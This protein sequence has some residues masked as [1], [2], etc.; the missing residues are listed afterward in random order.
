MDDD[1][2][3]DIFVFEGATTVMGTWT[4]PEAIELLEEALNHAGH[5]KPL[6]ERIRVKDEGTRSL[7]GLPIS[8]KVTDDTCDNHAR[9][10]W[11]L[12]NVLG[13]PLVPSPM[14]LQRIEVDE[15]ELRPLIFVN[16]PA[17]KRKT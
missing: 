5:L 2:A 13:L 7:I 16:I 1:E 6:W 8:S 10:L 14:A 9:H 15:A 3:D 11:S 12:L 4:Q 17:G